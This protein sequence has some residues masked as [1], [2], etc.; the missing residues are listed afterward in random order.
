MQAFAKVAT[1]DLLR[2]APPR[3]AIAAAAGLGYDGTMPDYIGTRA[4]N[5][6]ILGADDPQPVTVLDAVGEVSVLLICDHASNRVPRRLRDL[7]L[8]ADV[9]DRHIAWDVGAA[10]L[11]R[12]LAGR[13][14]APA[15]LAGYSRLVIDCNRQPGDPTSIPETSDDVGIPGNAG[16]SDGAAEARADEVFWPYHHAI[17]RELARLWRHE[18]PPILIAVHSFTPVM[19]GRPRPWQ[20]GVLWNRDPRLA[21]PLLARLR[22]HPDLC[23]GDNEPYSGRELGYTIDTHAAAAGLPHVSIEVRQDLIAA[24][25]GVATWGALLGDALAPLL[26]DPSLHRAELY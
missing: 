26:A 20:V 3:R 18:R 11:T 9:L 16:L 4:E 24:D 21:V 6:K 13:L 1:H 8:S 14:G 12:E 7:G 19:N 2:V 25:E 10:A 23:V 5:A 17:T 15:V 22:R